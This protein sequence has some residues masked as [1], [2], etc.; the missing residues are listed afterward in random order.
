VDEATLQ[1]RES[2]CLACPH[3]SAPRRLVQKLA[4]LGSAAADRTGARTG[5]RVCSECGCN[6]GKKMKLPTEACPVAHPTLPGLNRWGEPVAA[7][8]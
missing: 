1:R 2:A 4:G 7:L 3:L 5:D 6:V 8:P